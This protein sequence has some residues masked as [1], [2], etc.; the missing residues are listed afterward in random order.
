MGSYGI[1]VSRSVAAIAEQHHDE[2]GLIWPDEVAPADV[3][4]IAAGKDGQ[5]PAALELGAVLVGAGLR[6]LVDDRPQLSAGV[7]FTDAELIG[8][9]RA[10]VIGRRLSD[11]YAELRDRFTGER[12]DLPIGDVPGVITGTAG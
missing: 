4:I 7:K 12:R 1:G 5:I 6:V 2:R 11:G 10:V 3:H 9:R 8:I